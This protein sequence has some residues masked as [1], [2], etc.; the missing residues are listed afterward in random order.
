MRP[1]VSQASSMLI[2]RFLP[3]AGL[4]RAGRRAIRPG[5]PGPMAAAVIV[6]GLLLWAKL[7]LV[8]NHPR[9]AVARPDATATVPTDSATTAHPA[10]GR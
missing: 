1:A 4:R 6:L 3:G 9:T 7:L 5:R 2:S 8:T 10:D